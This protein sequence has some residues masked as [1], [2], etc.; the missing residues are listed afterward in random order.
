MEAAFR[1]PILLLFCSYAIGALLE[2][3][4][5]GTKVYSFFSARNYASDQ[6]TEYCG[7]LLLGLVIRKTPL[8]GFNPRLIYRGRPSIEKLSALKTEMDIAEIGHLIAFFVLG[9]FLLIPW[10]YYNIWYVLLLQVVNIIGNFY[11]VL[12]Q[13]YNKRR[14]DSLIA[15]LD[16][17]L[18]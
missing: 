5:R 3:I 13:Q 18:K 11:L 12:L 1:N 16:L 10:A 7:A 9:V 4:L 17:A 14:I 8:R 2:A 6:F 15:R